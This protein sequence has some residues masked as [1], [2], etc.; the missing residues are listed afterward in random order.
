MNNT[1]KTTIVGG[2]SITWMAIFMKDLCASRSMEG[3]T[4]V[5]QDLNKPGLKK[6][7]RFA[8]KLIG[9]R[10]CNIK[11]EIEQDLKA[12]ITGADFVINTVLVGS[13]ETWKNEQNTILKYG[14]Q[15]PKGMSVGPGGMIMGIKQIPFILHLA[16][17]MEEVCPEAWLFNFSN[18]MQLIM[19]AVQRYSKI[20]SIGICHGVKGTIDKIARRLDIPEQELTV[21]AG[22]VNHFEIITK[23]EY[24]G[25]DMFPAYMKRLDEIDAETGYSG[26]WIPRDMY[27]I[28]GG[29]PTNHD[30]HVIEFLPYY[31]HKGGDVTQFHQEQNYIENRIKGRD[32]R[33]QLFDAYLAGEKTFDEVEKPKS[34]EFLD[35]MVDA[36]VDNKPFL[37][38]GN[39]INNGYVTNLP[40]DISVAVPV[41]ISRDGLLG[42][43]IGDLPRGLAEFSALHGAIQNFMVEAA[44]TGS[45]ELLLAGL[46]MDPMCYSLTVQERKDLIDELLELDREFLPNFFR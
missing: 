26:E 13:H 40:R 37:L 33:W 2:A 24:N 35:K 1:V 39:V 31:I 8:Q 16:K 12:A 38:Y 5:L 23:L 27:K 17:L 43:C 34:T 21:V 20:K 3:G 4:V 7:Q 30:I 9:E 42:T 41:L 14:L 22:G 6:M 45:R 19:L 15:H 29:F 44:V 46:S 10:G 11:V 18:P 28:F 32:E 36:V 25:V